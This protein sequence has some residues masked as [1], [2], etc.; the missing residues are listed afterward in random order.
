ME[1]LRKLDKRQVFDILGSDKKGVVLAKKY[2]VSESTI[3]AVRLGVARPEIKAEFEKAK[4]W[5]RKIAVEIEEGVRS[6]AYYYLD[7]TTVRISVDDVLIS[8]DL[9]NGKLVG[10]STNH[11]IKGHRMDYET[12]LSM[13]IEEKFI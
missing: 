8:I 11:E 2:G 10:I 9:H 13:L 3:T 4:E 5:E 7:G 6:N 12:F 1:S